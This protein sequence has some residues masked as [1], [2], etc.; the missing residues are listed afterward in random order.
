VRFASTIFQR[1]RFRHAAD[2]RHGEIEHEFLARLRGETIR[3]M[4]AVSV[5]VPQT[6]AGSF[7]ICTWLFEIRRLCP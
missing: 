3:V 5:S 2:L 4:L 1:R 6:L 7:A